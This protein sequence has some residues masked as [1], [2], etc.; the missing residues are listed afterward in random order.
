M[1]DRITAAEKQVEEL[2][3]KMEDPKVLADHVQLA[4]VCRQMESAQLQAR[5]LWARWEELQAKQQA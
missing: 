2:H 3:Q 5:Q 1:E 4:E